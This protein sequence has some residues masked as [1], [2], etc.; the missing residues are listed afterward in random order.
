[1]NHS[2][3]WSRSNIMGR[4]RKGKSEQLDSDYEIFRY[5]R[6]KT[7][8]KTSEKKKPNKKKNMKKESKDE[9]QETPQKGF[10][11]NL[12]K[13]LLQQWGQAKG[14]KFNSQTPTQE[15]NQA[16]K[17]PTPILRTPINKSNRSRSFT[18]INMKELNSFKDLENELNKLLFEYKKERI[19]LISKDKIWD[20]LQYNEAQFFL[21]LPNVCYPE[22]TSKYHELVPGEKNL[23]L[24][25]IENKISKKGYDS[26]ERIKK[27]LKLIKSNIEM[28][29]GKKHELSNA[30]NMLY[31]DFKPICMRLSNQ[32]DKLTESYLVK[33]LK[34]I[35]CP[36][37]FFESLKKK[38]FLKHLSP[39]TLSKRK[40]NDNF[41]ER[42][43]GLSQTRKRS[44]SEGN[45]KPISLKL[46]PLGQRKLKKRRL[47]H[48]Q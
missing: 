29:Y 23:N 41:Y 1:M 36:E 22:F 7:D 24:Y 2:Q 15:D 26:I 17:N 27:D 3:D 21:F 45:I 19:K 47:L 33:K 37:Q 16:T 32:L 6:N 13:K 40:K 30:I 20:L 28:V 43:F 31:S 35:N 10:R 14:I 42:K 11:T 18:P 39:K 38:L 48:T 46:T 5:T 34:T 9:K 44:H 4:L 8:F 12:E 25:D